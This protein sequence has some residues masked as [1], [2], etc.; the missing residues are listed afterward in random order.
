M[1]IAIIN[2][3]NLN[4]TGIREPHIYGTQSLT[5]INT[6]IAAAFDEITFEFF[7]S[8][9]EGEIIDFIQKCHLEKFDGIVINPGA[10]SHYSY[11]IRDAAAG[12]APPVIEAHMSNPYAREDFRQKSVIAPVCHGQIS[13]FGHRSYILAVHALTNIIN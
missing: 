4:F 13:G 1:K 7:Q 8:N 12:V 11:A 9:I 5:E 6:Q 10:F 3:P 2:G